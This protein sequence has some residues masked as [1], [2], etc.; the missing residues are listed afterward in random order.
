MRSDAYDP[1]VVLSGP[2]GDTIHEQDDGGEDFDTQF[3]A[4]LPEDG[5][6]TIWAGSSSGTATGQFTLALERA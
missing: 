5:T 1:Y 3:T 4:T 6:Y 2:E